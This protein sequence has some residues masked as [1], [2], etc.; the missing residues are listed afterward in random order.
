MK[1]VITSWYY[2]LKFVINYARR[3]AKSDL[4]RKLDFLLVD[5]SFAHS[6]LHNERG[7]IQ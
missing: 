7:I 2:L 6:Q 5:F 1:L 3:P 4:A